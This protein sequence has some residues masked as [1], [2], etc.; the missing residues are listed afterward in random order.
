MPQ[1]R[2]QI[3]LKS[4][5]KASSRKR[6]RKPLPPDLKALRQ[7]KS[8]PPPPQTLRPHR[9]L[10]SVK[11]PLQPASFTY[12]GLPHASPASPTSSTA[13]SQS[14]ASKTG[15]TS[16]AW[17]GA[18]PGGG[19]RSLSLSQPPHKANAAAQGKNKELAKG[20]ES[21][22]SESSGALKMGFGTA[23][24]QRGLASHKQQN[25]SGA[26]QPSNQSPALSLRTLN[27]QNLQEKSPQRLRSK[28]AARNPEH[29]NSEV[30]EAESEDEEDEDS[31]SDSDR[32]EAD[33]GNANAAAPKAQVLF[34]A[35][36]RPSL[37]AHVDSDS[38]DAEE[39]NWR[40]SRNV[41]EHVFV[42]D[43]TANFITV[44]VK[45]SPTSVG[46]FSS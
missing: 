26:K 10:S 4:D 43:V 32:S 29:R 2:P 41:L 35:E 36:A 25:N 39:S 8:R 5:H 23:G 44:T 24:V 34:P 13:F 3:L 21:K 22:R 27:L 6:G 18:P 7:S 14:G 45:E 17:P 16:G 40:P 30:S 33:V 37:G 12:T 20:A 19:G 9:D 1:K 15:T 38:E 28:D 11:K 42:T 46:F 31:S